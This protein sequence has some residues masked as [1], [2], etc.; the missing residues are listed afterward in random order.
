MDWKR[1]GR[2]LNTPVDKLRA[3]FASDSQERRLAAWEKKMEAQTRELAHVTSLLR[4]ALERRRAAL[5]EVTALDARAEE[6]LRDGDE[7]KARDVLLA[8]QDAVAR[9]SQAKQESEA[10]AGAMRAGR[11]TLA[12]T[13][14]EANALLAEAGMP[15]LSES[16]TKAEPSATAEEPAKD[17]EQREPAPDPDAPRVRIK[18]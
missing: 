13:R 17:D 12:A 6:A 18:I 1:V 9:L 16:S 5:A 11:D 14:A 2:L 15:P 7:A 8:K 10:L 3:R 4:D